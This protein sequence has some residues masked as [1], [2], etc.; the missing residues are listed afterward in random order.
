MENMMSKLEETCRYIRSRTRLKPAIG[1]ILGS[2]LGKFAS[3]INVETKLDY[4]AIPHFPKATVLGHT[5]ELISGRCGDRPVLVMGGRFHYYEGH[6]MNEVAYPVRVM[7]M[8]G[9]RTLLISNA[10]GGMNPNFR[11]GDLMVL[12]DHINLQAENPL[13]GPN[14][15]SF[16][17]RFPDMSEPY[18]H[19]LVEKA[20]AIGKRNDIP[21]HSG[22]YAGVQGP[23]FET[24]AEYRYLHRI[25][26]D[27]V[28]M[29]TVS[30]VIT[31][32]HAGMRVLAMS[33]ITDLGIREE[34]NRIT[35]EEV[36]AA[37]EA[38]E[39]KLTVI[40]KELIASL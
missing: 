19:E 5:G 21:L 15:D 12:T 39:P 18:S 11:V 7:A 32:V 36:L 8:L 34:E 33:V 31:A 1:I 24:R 14:L 9:I 17:P 30:E 20:L 26:A 29:S 37:A 28:G 2:G 22:V 16:G 38:A 23:S 40:F 6:T 27:A 35:H 10:A 25:G 4:T 3:Q 13:R